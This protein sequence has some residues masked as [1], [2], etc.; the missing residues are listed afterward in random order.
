MVA[1]LSLPQPHA[2]SRYFLLQNRTTILEPGTGYLLG[3]S[4]P[5]SCLVILLNE[6]KFERSVFLAHNRVV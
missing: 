4:F 5:L 6:I 3:R 2:F 1:L